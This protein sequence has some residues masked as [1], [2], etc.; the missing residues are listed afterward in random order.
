MPGGQGTLFW[1]FCFSEVR[2]QHVLFPWRMKD[3]GLLVNRIERC[4]IIDLVRVGQRSHVNFT[5]ATFLCILTE[6]SYHWER[7]CVDVVSGLTTSTQLRSQ[8]KRELYL[9]IYF[10]TVS[11]VR[12]ERMAERLKL[13]RSSFTWE[14]SKSADL[15]VAEH[16]YVT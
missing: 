15:Q 9:F 13:V 12:I 16:V 6:T 5:V 8:S 7:S 11:N 14:N 10:F 4:P 2:V 1:F 3:G